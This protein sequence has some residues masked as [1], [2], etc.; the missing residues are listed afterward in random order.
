VV[1]VVVAVDSEVLG[2]PVEEGEE[3]GFVVEVENMSEEVVEES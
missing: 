2:W 1:V 3:V